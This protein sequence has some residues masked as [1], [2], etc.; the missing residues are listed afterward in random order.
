M[1]AKS[2]SSITLARMRLFAAAAGI[3]LSAA[4][5]GATMRA[6]RSLAPPGL[7]GTTTR[8]GRTGY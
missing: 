6:M 8:T 2:A 1:A 7:E 4:S 3:L 5:A